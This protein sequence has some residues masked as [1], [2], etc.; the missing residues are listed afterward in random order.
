MIVAGIGCR[1]GVGDSGGAG[2]D[3]C[4]AG[5]QHGLDAR[6]RYRRWRRRQSSA[7][8]RRSMPRPDAGAERSLVLVA[9]GRLS[10]PSGTAPA[11]F[12][13][14]RPVAS[15]W[16]ARRRSRKQPRLPRAGEPAQGCSARA[17]WSA[18]SPAPSPFGGDDGMTVHFIGAGPGAADLI[19]V[20][21]A[22]CSPRCPVCLYAG[23]IVSPEL[24]Q[25]CAPRREAGRHRAAVARRDRGRIFWPRTQPGRTSRGCIPAICRCGA[26]LPSRSGGW[27]STASPTR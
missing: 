19:T 17:S 27:R 24:L 22:T 21:G 12:T 13:R 4:G 8:S 18:R 15:K 5:R 3:R 23:S 6:R 1:K 20:R 11:R 9:R 25:Y 14:L 7:T 10:R 26:R 16:P 2:R